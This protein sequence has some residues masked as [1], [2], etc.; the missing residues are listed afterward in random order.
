[1]NFLKNS[2]ERF[3]L[4]LIQPTLE[5]YMSTQIDNLNAQIAALSDEVTK[6]IAAEEADKQAAID[7]VATKA[8]LADEQAKLAAA[9]TALG[10]ANASLADTNAAVDVSAATVKAEADAVDAVLNPAPVANT[11]PAPTV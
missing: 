5:K 10:T 9:N 6:L 2:W 7:L 3:I 8:A 11:T 4:F 1:M